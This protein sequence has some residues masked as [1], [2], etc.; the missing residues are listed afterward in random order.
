MNPETVIRDRLEVMVEGPD[1]SVLRLG[2]LVPLSGPLGLVGPS[3]TCAASLAAAEVNAAG[4]VRG[5]RIELVVADA[6]GRPD[7][8]AREAR[9]LAESGTVEAVVGLHTSD[10][11]R[12]VESALAG[13]M[14]YIF[15]PPH[16]GGS[17]RTGVVLL[18]EAPAQQ[19]A[20]PLG[21]LS[22]QRRLRRWALVGS[23]YIWAWS[24]H[25]AARPLIAAFGGELAL[26]RLIPFGMSEDAAGHVTQALA[27][28]RVDAV[29]L[30]LIGRDL[31]LFN[32]AFTASRLGPNVLR[33][34]GALEENG[35]L[36]A[37]GDDTGELYAAM[38]SFAGQQ[39]PRRLA[40]AEN[41]RR[42]FGPHAPPLDSYSESCYDGTHLAAA[43]AA[44][45]GLTAP[46][47]Q[48]VAARL[49]SPD[50]S[51]LTRLAWSRAP[52]G[53]PRRGTC[54]AR[55]DGLELA[56]VAPPDKLGVPG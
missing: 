46:R 45:D 9:R 29:L 54:L 23:D 17:R 4:G 30:S 51:A 44:A 28:A 5:R 42:A 47:A 24:V 40:L 20:L 33:V 12:A 27:R 38:R 14:P 6:G 56:V 50:G 11:H 32:R 36:A 22:R 35:L 52:L 55:A 26:E 37:G 1:A 48:P 49:L 25:R 7:S 31:V 34:S 10:V 18:G 39:E 21:W 53:R 8:A 15:T 13:R 41:Y 19:L 2:L 43:L 3:A 16:E